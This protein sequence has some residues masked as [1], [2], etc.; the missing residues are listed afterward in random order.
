M[1]Q[2]I[3]HRATGIANTIGLFILVWWLIAAASGPNAYEIFL[4][5]ASHPIGRIMMM[6]WVFSVYAHMLGG[7]RHMIM[8][9]G[10]LYEIRTAKLVVLFVWVAS[11]VLT[12]A[13]WM[14]I[15]GGEQ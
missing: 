6:G 1:T 3:L 8:D 7:I 5:F 13:T 11:A 15:F 2:S 14:T 4:T 10:R 12:L 9:T